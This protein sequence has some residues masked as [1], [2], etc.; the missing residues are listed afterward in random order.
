M[1][2]NTPDQKLY[3]REFISR[4]Y[5]I[6]EMKSLCDNLGENWEDITNET[7]RERFAQEIVEY[8]DRR[9]R[10]IDLWSQVKEDRPYFFTASSQTRE[11]PQDI[12]Y[13]NREDSQNTYY[14]EY[15]D[16]EYEDTILKRYSTYIFFAIAIIL[17]AAFYNSPSYKLKD[18]EYFVNRYIQRL[19]AG[20]TLQAWEQLHGDYRIQK[21]PA[22]Y[23]SYE[24]IFDGYKRIEI[25]K[26]EVGEDTGTQA[27]VRVF[28][29]LTNWED[30]VSNQDITYQL[31]R[32]TEK[33]SWL[34][35]NSSP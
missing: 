30:I 19:N 22:G 3:L 26:I 16:D 12:Y 14:D 34:I 11:E 28:L 32:P 5:N 29:A 27:S 33:D 15:E 7:T 23:P 31:S 18:P 13:K 8:F 24:D 17:I 2:T 21:Y 1:N 25:L 4:A 35:I 10:L 6:N 9:G 20:S